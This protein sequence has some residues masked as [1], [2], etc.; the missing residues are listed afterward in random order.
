MDII[1]ILGNL[2][3]GAIGG[4]L[5]G[6][7]LKQMTLGTIGNTI[8]GAVG[9]VA[10]GYILQILGVLSATGL[11]DMSVE[12]MAAQGGSAAIIGAI[13]TAVSGFIKNKMSN[14]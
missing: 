3:S 4:N 6:A 13:V 14:K 10:G 2:I 1:G 9:G 7:A 5:S 8:A 11:T 12:S